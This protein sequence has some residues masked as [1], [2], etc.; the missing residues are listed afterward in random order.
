MA[1]ERR[2][3]KEMGGRIQPKG[4]RVPAKNPINQDDRIRVG[5]LRI[6]RY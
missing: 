2:G 5:D 3:Y 6:V 1:S 4:V